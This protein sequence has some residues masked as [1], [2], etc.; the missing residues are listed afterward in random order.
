MLLVGLMEVEEDQE[1]EEEDKLLLLKE[2]RL[3]LL[4]L[5]CQR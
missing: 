1:E 2:T 3:C 5:T 4:K